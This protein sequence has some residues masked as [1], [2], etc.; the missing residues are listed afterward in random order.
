MLIVHGKS[1]ISAELF[2]SGLWFISR[3]FVRKKSV[4]DTETSP[5]SSLWPAV[6]RVIPDDCI[7]DLEQILCVFES[8]G[9]CFVTE[10]KFVI[11]NPEKRIYTNAKVFILTAEKSS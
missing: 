10:R 2:M 7:R 8:I 9:G 11:T 6:F 5:L 1:N 4:D 3:G